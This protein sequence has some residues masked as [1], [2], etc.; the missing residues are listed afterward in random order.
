MTFESAKN[1]HRGAVKR[2]V[3]DGKEK[4]WMSFCFASSINPSEIWLNDHPELE[5]QV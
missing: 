1:T 3:W 5:E 4:R 2:V